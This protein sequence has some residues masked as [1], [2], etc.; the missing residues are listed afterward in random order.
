MQILDGAQFSLSSGI[1]WEAGAGAELLQEW[2][3]VREDNVRCPEGKLGFPD[4][5]WSRDSSNGVK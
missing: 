2:V 5:S 1:G 3:E 4:K